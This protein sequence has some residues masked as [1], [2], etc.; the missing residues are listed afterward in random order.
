MTSALG[1]YH[2]IIVHFAIGLLFAGVLFRWLF[3][4][5]KASFAGPSAAILIL[6]GTLAAYGAIL[7]GEV[8]HRPVERVPGSA[9]MVV[10]HEMWADRTIKIFLAVAA[11]ELLGLLLSRRGRF[12]I[13]H[14]AAAVVGL[15]GLFSLYMT[16]KHGG[17]LVYSYAGGV[18]IRTGDKE[19]VGRLLLAG[20]YHQAELDRQEGRPAEANQL[21]Q[22]M[23]QRF[24][25][26]PAIQLLAA[27][28]TLLD[29]KDASGALQAIEKITVSPEDRRLLV[30]RGLLLADAQAA[31]GQKEAASETLKDL[32][33]NFPNSPQL[34][35]RLESL[36]K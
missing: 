31:A 30:R 13:I 23:Q 35:Q 18:G 28:S 4:T 11:L 34:R 22:E 36:E 26:D 27:E 14:Y 17:E 20:M 1:P 19:D 2:P 7:S 33:K 8:A 10:E 15:A 3:L 5:R 32:Q 21:L 29:L 25:A 9:G 12:R 16:G 6:A 24:P